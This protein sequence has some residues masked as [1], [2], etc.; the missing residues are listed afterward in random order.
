MCDCKPDAPAADLAMVRLHHP[1]ERGF[2]FAGVDPCIAP[3]VQTLNDGGYQTTASC[4]GHGRRPGII[5]LEDGREL[6]VMPDL[7]TARRIDH[8]FPD[9]HGNPVAA[10]AGG[11]AA[12]REFTC[13]RCE[14][15]TKDETVD[16]GGFEGLRTGCTICAW[17]DEPERRFRL[18][19]RSQPP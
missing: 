1:T 8:L 3:L 16:M 17:P 5:T 7:G 9:I 13:P 12:D 15:P 4:C 6:I 10:R 14:A 11:S 19:V 18:V 2:V